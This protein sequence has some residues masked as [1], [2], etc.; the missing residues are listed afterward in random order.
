VSDAGSPESRDGPGGP[1][2]ADE[3]RRLIDERLTEVTAPQRVR[4]LPRPRL[5]ALASMLSPG[6]DP[7]RATDD[8]RELMTLLGMDG[9]FAE[10]ELSELLSLAG[11]W[12]VELTDMIPIAQAYYRGVARIVE[13]EVE[14][15]EDLLR[16][17]PT[18]ERLKLLED[19]LE[20]PVMDAPGRVFALLHA[21]LL[22]AALLDELS[23]S[24]LEAPAASLAIGLVDLT[25]STAYL[26]QCGR[27]A[28]Q[29]LVDAL[30]QA[31]QAATAT[32]PTRVIKYVGD[33]MFLAA[34]E[35]VQVADACFEAIDLLAQSVELPSRAGLAYG[36]LVRH[37]GDYFGF[38]V[39]MSQRLTK[40]ASPSSVLA[41]TEAAAQIE[42]ARHGHRRRLRLPGTSRRRVAVELTRSPGSP[43][44]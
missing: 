7:S 1:S 24:E 8:T 3:L 6:A 25:G 4:L 17:A 16:R 41:S 14:A 29:G 36:P 27:E 21:S 2:E 39:N 42:P 43:A 10:H 30:F 26:E 38:P 18:G 23:T 11:S 9:R 35:P 33:G 32:R 22:R 12:G 40:V 19:L 44:R 37:A 28:T 13:A 34:R 15:V 20:D 31:G 5:R